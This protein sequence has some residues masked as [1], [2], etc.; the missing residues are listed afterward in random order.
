[1][2]KNSDGQKS[3]CTGGGKET[4]SECIDIHHF[5]FILLI[6]VRAL[7]LDRAKISRQSMKI[8]ATTGIILS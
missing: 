3:I 4:V 1:M 6:L 7:D 8:L 5:V 2:E